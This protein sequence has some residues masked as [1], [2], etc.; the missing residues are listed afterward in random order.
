MSLETCRIGCIVSG[1][2]SLIKLRHRPKDCKEPLMFLIKFFAID[3]Q[4]HTN[5]RLSNGSGTQLY[6]D[7][8]NFHESNS[9]FF[10]TGTIL[11]FGCDDPMHCGSIRSEFVDELPL[12]WF[13]PGYRIR[14]IHRGASSE[15]IVLDLTDPDS[16]EK[17][18]F[19][20][21]RPGLSEHQKRNLRALE[22]LC[23]TTS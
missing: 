14:L 10:I 21:K 9:G 7:V 22:N 4:G 2:V 1:G 15:G 17:L 20:S 6:V 23:K 16:E 5:R 13:Q 18:Q 19:Y 3:K 8:S 12:K 11:K